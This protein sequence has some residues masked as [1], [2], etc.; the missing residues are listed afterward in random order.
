ME[1]CEFAPP[2]QAFRVLETE[3]SITG[4]STVELA[5][6]VAY[7]IPL[8]DPEVDEALYLHIIAES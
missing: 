4:Q 1:V 2:E 8:N 6:K 3:V 5:D 7:K